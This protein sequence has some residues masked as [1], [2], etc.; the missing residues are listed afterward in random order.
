MHI[1]CKMNKPARPLLKRRSD[2][3]TIAVKFGN[4]FARLFDMSYVKHVYLMNSLIKYWSKQ[5]DEHGWRRLNGKRA[6]PYDKQ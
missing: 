5:I 4:S 3:H 1:S 6:L 2:A